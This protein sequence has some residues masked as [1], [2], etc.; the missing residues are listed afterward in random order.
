MTNVEVVT[1]GSASSAPWLLLA[2]PGIALTLLATAVMGY[3]ALSL[4][5][6]AGASTVASY[7]F[8]SEAMLEAGG[9][10]YASRHAYV[11][12]CVLNAGAACILALALAQ[13]AR[14]RRV[15]WLVA[16]YV[17]VAL[18]LAVVWYPTWGSR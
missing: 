1:R 11:V 17:G 14:R 13:G 9:W 8:G 3:E 15:S 4:G 5:V 6:F 2:A 7:Q 18:W 16:G 12:S 10:A